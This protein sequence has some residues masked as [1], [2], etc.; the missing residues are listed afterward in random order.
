MKTQSISHHIELNRI[1][2]VIFA[3]STLALT[4]SYFFEI[5]FSSNLCNLCKVQ[6]LGFFLLSI[7]SFLGI[8]LSAK[9]LVGIFLLCISTFIFFISFYH[10]G[11]QYEIF[12][13]FCNFQAPLDFESYKNSLFYKEFSCSKIYYFLGIPLG[14]WSLSFSFLC[15][16]LS[17][18]IRNLPN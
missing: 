2:V 1:I 6:R 10:L 4:G 16:I 13:D 12:K 3:I 17:R 18:K 7:F 15:F 8:F 9:R 5:L 14:F 11:I